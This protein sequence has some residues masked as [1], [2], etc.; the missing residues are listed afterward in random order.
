M[1]ELFLDLR[2]KLLF[3][4]APKSFSAEAVKVQDLL[5]EKIKTDSK[6]AYDYSLIASDLF[7][8]LNS[9]LL[10]WVINP[11]IAKDELKEEDLEIARNGFLD[12]ASH[13]GGKRLREATLEELKNIQKSQTRRFSELYDKGELKTVYGHDFAYGLTFGMRRGARWVTSNPAKICLYEKDLPKE[14]NRVLS[15]IKAENESISVEDFTSMIFTKICSLSAREL[16]PIFELTDGEY[17]FVCVQVSPLQYKN[18]EK[19][20]AQADYW[21]EAFK[22][23]LKTDKPNIV[24]KLPAVPASK[25]AA[26]ALIEHGYRICMTLDFSVSQHEIFAEI[27]QKGDKRG[28]VVFMGGYLDD[29]VKKELIA[30]GWPEEEAVMVSRH[31]SEAVIR[32]SYNNLKNKGY[33]KVSIMTAAVRGPW[34]MINS[35][36]PGDGQTILITTTKENIDLFDSEER[37]LEPVLDQ[38]TEKEY[39]DKLVQS[40]VFNKA[41][42]DLSSGDFGFDNPYDYPPLV[43]VQSGFEN[44]YRQTSKTAED[45]LAY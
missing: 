11:A 43:N 10:Q 45:M 27:I 13:F 1:H 32:K 42:A 37:I 20:V 19:M 23:E 26:E 25:E 30:K 21:W 24:F 36:S 8:D 29:A 4:D 17:G 28:Y 40:D 41:Y 38:A 22:K 33:D 16:R 7:L 31:A 6:H 5:K 35:L 44:N 9:Y 14:Y 39:M 18:T 34:S 2:K 12:L 3:I 15:E